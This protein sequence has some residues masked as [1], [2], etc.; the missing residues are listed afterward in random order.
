MGKYRFKVSRQAKAWF[1]DIVT[2]EANSKDEAE[3]ILREEAEE[4]AYGLW[5]TDVELEESNVDY[6]TVE[7]LESVKI[8]LIKGE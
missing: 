1:D 7:Y 8:E 4:G 2:V 6:D 3:E 5:S